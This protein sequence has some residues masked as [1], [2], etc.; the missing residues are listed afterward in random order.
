MT[1]QLQDVSSRRLPEADAVAHSPTIAFRKNS[2]PGRTQLTF[3]LATMQSRD[4]IPG[5]LLARRSGPG[6]RT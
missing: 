4:R 6:R 1:E 3:A 5:R 2:R